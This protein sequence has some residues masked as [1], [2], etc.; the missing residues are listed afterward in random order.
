VALSGGISAARR[1]LFGTRPDTQGMYM[2]IAQA[3]SVVGS[4]PYADYLTA[5]DTRVT[6]A[7]HSVDPRGLPSIVSS[8][9]SGGPLVV[10]GSWG[11]PAGDGRSVASWRVDWSP[12]GGVVAGTETA[13]DEVGG[14]SS[15]RLPGSSLYVSGTSVP[16]SGSWLVERKEMVGPLSGAIE[17]V[18]AS[19]QAVGALFPPDRGEP[20][21]TFHELS[22]HALFPH[23]AAGVVLA[24]VYG[25][26]EFRRWA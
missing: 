18:L 24:L 25:I 1:L 10:S 15:F 26:E 22:Q 21:N 12:A 5:L 9:S 3:L 6:H 20:W 4:T 8:A 17:A 16:T 23:R 13:G 2:R 14:S 19:E 11:I 7:F